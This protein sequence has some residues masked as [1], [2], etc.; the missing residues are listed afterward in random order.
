MER[1]SAMERIYW[2]YGLLLTILVIAGV[3]CGLDKLSEEN[4]MTIVFS[5]LSAILGGATGYYYSLART[6]GG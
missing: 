3:L 6:R 4:F 5:I 2:V 1:I